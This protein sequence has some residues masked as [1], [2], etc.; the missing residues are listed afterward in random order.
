MGTNPTFI[1]PLDSASTLT[2][3]LGYV[4]VSVSMSGADLTLVAG[5]TFIASDA[6]CVIQVSGNDGATPPVWTS[7][8]TTIVSVADPTHATLAAAPASAITA[9]QAIFYRPIQG[10]PPYTTPQTSNSRV[11]VSAILSVSSEFRQCTG[12]A[13]YAAFYVGPIGLVGGSA[14]VLFDNGP[15]WTQRTDTFPLTAEAL[16]ALKANTLHAQFDIEGSLSGDATGDPAELLIYETWLDVIYGD[17]GTARLV[18]Y[19]V[20]T[21]PGSTGGI[22]NEQLAIDGDLTSAATISRGHFSGLSSGWILQLIKFKGLRDAVATWR[23]YYYLRMGSIDFESAL[24]TSPTLNFDVFSSDGN[25]APQVGQP[26]LMTDSSLLSAPFGGAQGDVFGGSIEQIEI[27]NVPGTDAVICKCECRS[28]DQILSRRV[29][30]MTDG[31]PTPPSSIIFNGG[32]IK[33]DI[34]F[35]SWGKRR[36]F[37]LDPV[38]VSIVSVTLGGVRQT[39]GPI[40]DVT[41]SPFPLLPLL[42]PPPTGPDDWY[43]SPGWQY[44]IQDVGGAT[45]NPGEF[46]EIIVDPVAQAIPSIYYE[47]ATA[48]SIIRALLALIAGPEGIELPFIVPGPIIQAISFTGDSTFDSALSSIL[49]YINTGP[50]AFWYY[51]DPRKG[52]HFE[53]QGVTNAAPWNISQDDASDSNVLIAVGNAITREKYTNAAYLSSSE[54]LAPATQQFVGDS[55]TASFNLSYPAGSTPVITFYPG[56][57]GTPPAICPPVGTGVPG[58]NVVQTQTVGVSGQTGFDWYWSYGS[59]EITQDPQWPPITKNAA[60]YVVYEPLVQILQPYTDEDSVAERQAI[61]GGS[62]EYDVT[63]DVSAGLPMMQGVPASSPGANVLETLAQYYSY[64]AETLT[65]RTYRSG[66]VPGQSIAIN[67]GT[68]A[69]GSFVVQSV[70]LS[71]EGNLKLW[72]NTY[73]A[74][75]LIGDWK[76]AVKYMTGGSGGGS[77]GGGSPAAIGGPADPG[78]SSPSNALALQ[79]DGTVNNNQSLLNLISGNGIT[80]TDGGAGNVTVAGLSLETN[81]AANADQKLLNLVAGTGVAITDDGAGDITISSST[82]I[83]FS[84]EAPAGTLDGSNVTFTLTHAPSPPESLLLTLNGVEQSPGFGSPATGAD[85]SIS[86]AT[87]TFTAAPRAADWVMAFYTH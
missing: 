29:L 5:A 18:P 59:S 80:V 52:F 13:A 17:G 7:L 42:F 36:Y 68:V 71:D 81:G 21:V 33:N 83:A 19:T 22:V 43:W 26:V 87:I 8:W 34:D 64:M 57:S 84:R 70:R 75:A 79:V 10:D 37:P 73:I 69:S 40:T 14:P 3:S 27:D 30:G 11:V 85:Y 48:D 74:G 56:N 67:L 54:T 9:G 82:S 12:Y 41:V 38:P 60:I 63:L 45:P 6:G 24:S 58:G 86:G 28:W 78:T 2:I 77:G 53:I 23:S 35:P 47:S 31:F 49:S 66:H 50:Q 44:L 20:N 15:G 16:A 65:V 1:P 61:E 72:E 32:Q 46:I 62:G 51:I 76:T 55:S 39:V 25:F 4:N